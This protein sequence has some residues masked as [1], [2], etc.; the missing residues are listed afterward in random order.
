MK[1]TDDGT[2]RAHLL[3][4]PFAVDKGP[5]T[6]PVANPH[7]AA[8]PVR[9]LYT[10]SQY[11]EATVPLPD[12]HV[13]IQSVD[14]A[15]ANPSAPPWGDC[16]FPHAMPEEGTKSPAPMP[17]HPPK[18][19]LQHRP[20]GALSSCCSTSRP[21]TPPATATGQVPSHTHSEEEVSGLD[22]PPAQPHATGTCCS[23]SH[24]SSEDSSLKHLGDTG[25][26]V[27][28]S[29]HEDL[30][31]G[32]PNFERVLLR[33]DG[34]KCGCCESGLSRAVSRIPA[35][36]NFQ[37]NTVLARVELELDTNRL[38]VDKVIELLGTRTGYKFEEQ[39]TIAGQ[40]LEFIITD[41]R[42]L[43]HAI[44]PNGVT[45][46]E[47]PERAPWRPFGLLSGRKNTTPKKTSSA[48]GSEELVANVDNKP[49]VRYRNPFILYETS[50]T[51]V[52]LVPAQSR[53][54][55]YRRQG[56]TMMRLLSE[57]ETSTSTTSNMIPT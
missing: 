12:Q 29:E 1:S 8:Y 14:G 19:K 5:S 11:S 37:V 28:M 45:R 7:A 2:P 16:Q 43:Q 25:D 27:I 51:G 54:Y 32:P 53:K 22:T 10:D 49:D 34:L 26:N 21:D 38:S 50:L 56:S 6:L 4:L 9:R 48:N 55:E 33:I 40:V 35:I 18:T 24:C 15:T 42:R 36:R 52:M 30:E 39:V 20:F 57:L 41:P 46:V 3:R 13:A 47:V 31:L 23:E 44:Q 17:V